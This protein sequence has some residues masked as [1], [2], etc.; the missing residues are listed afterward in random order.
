MKEKKRV[1]SEISVGVLLGMG[2]L[3]SLFILHSTWSGA[4][5]YSSPTVILSSRGP[6]KHIIDDYREAYHWLRMN[7]KQDAKVMSWWDYGYQ[8]TGLANRTVLVDNNTWNYTHIATVGKVY[9]I[10]IYI[11]IGICK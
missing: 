7:S 10:Y 4:E 9:I 1:P 3:L 5:A 2:V 6:P 8:L 11:Y